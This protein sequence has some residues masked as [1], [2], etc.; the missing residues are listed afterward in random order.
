[1]RSTHLPNPAKLCALLVYPNQ[2]TADTLAKLFSACGQQVLVACDGA[3]A[4]KLAQ[5]HQLDLVIWD[6]RLRTVYQRLNLKEATFVAIT[7]SEAEFARGWTENDFVHYL[8]EPIDP[9]QVQALLSKL[10]RDRFDSQL[11]EDPTTN[12]TLLPPRP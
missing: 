5:T 7:S 9:V 1:M 10:K 12:P 8:V 2:Q 3:T 4:C 11:K 6:T